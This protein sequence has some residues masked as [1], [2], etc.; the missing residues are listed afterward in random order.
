MT[1]DCQDLFRR[2]AVFAGGFTAESAD[3]VCGD[4]LDGVAE[5]VEA[6]LL[7]PPDETG[8]PPRFSMLATIRKYA[9]ELLEESGEADQQRQ[10][11]AKHFTIRAE[12]W[13]S[14]V[15]SPD[16]SAVL[17]RLRQE[18]NNLRA[19][20]DWCC[21][22]AGD[23]SL[24]LRLA[25]ALLPY[26]QIS[27]GATEGRYWLGVLLDRTDEAAPG[28]RA[29][30][31]HAAGVL[32]REQGDAATAWPLLETAL[33]LYREAGDE[34]GTVDVLHA[35]A[36]R[37]L[38]TGKYPQGIVHLEEALAMRR[39]AGDLAGVAETLGALSSMYGLRNDVSIA[40]SL[41]EEAVALRRR[42]G[43]TWGMTVV[44]STLGLT[45]ALVGELDVAEPLL[46]EALQ[47]Q[48]SLGNRAGTA[49]SFYGLAVIARK[50][51]GTV[52]ARDCCRKSIVAWH[53]TGNAFQIG[54]PL[55]EMA[56][57][58]TLEGG[59]IVGAQLLG[60]VTEHERRLGLA[61]SPRSRRT[62]DATVE[63]ARW[64]LSDVEFDTAYRAG[65]QLSLDQAVELALA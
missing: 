16:G 51:G 10:R 4:V 45:R 46:R 14:S 24:G 61:R 23:P 57:I 47:L 31:C 2:L 49:L 17:S 18:A 48:E 65:S 59:A 52:S 42:L 33:T 34:R 13:G 40:I 22:D 25:A 62:Y 20:L 8:N 43:D 19:A 38:V 35:L 63:A 12:D 7:L 6:N 64:L 3:A 15:S 55:Q 9:G 27:G 5:L 32:A 39:A 53:E 11:H 1:A 36:Y 60:F 21:S 54:I 28:T 50:R 37:D 29:R 58:S 44:L 56:L 30:A 26:W 41:L